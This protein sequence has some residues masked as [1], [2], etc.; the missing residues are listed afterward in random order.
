MSKMSVSVSSRQHTPPVAAVRSVN[1][2]L[3]LADCSNIRL[4]PEVAAVNCSDAKFGCHA[5]K[6]LT[7]R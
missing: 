1:T 2:F 7:V 4:M 5:G 3:T 6:N